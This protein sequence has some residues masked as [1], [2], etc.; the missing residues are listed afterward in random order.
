MFCFC[1]FNHARGVG[2]DKP[3]AEPPNESLRLSPQTPS[4]NVYVNGWGRGGNGGRTA[5]FGAPPR[6]RLSASDSDDLENEQE[7]KGKGKPAEAV[8]GELGG[9]SNIGF[10]DDALAAGGAG[11]GD[12]G[13]TWAK[14]PPSL[15]PPP[16]PATVLPAPLGRRRPLQI[17]ARQPAPAASSNGSG[18]VDASKVQ[19]PAVADA[20]EAAGGDEDEDE[21]EGEGKGEESAAGDGGRV[22][23]SS[24]SGARSAAAATAAADA[25]V[26]APPSASA[27]APETVDHFPCSLSEAPPPPSRSHKQS[28]PWSTSSPCVISCSPSSPSFGGD[29]VRLQDG[30]GSGSGSGSGFEHCARAVR[31]CELYQEC[32]HILMPPAASGNG[33][34]NSKGNG[35]DAGRNSGGGGDGGGFATLMHR[36]EKDGSMAG[37]EAAAAA[38]ARAGNGGG[39]GSGSGGW[40]GS[41]GGF[42][43][44]AKPRTYYVVSFGGSGSKMLG[45]WLSERGKGMVKEVRRRAASI[46]LGVCVS[47][48]AR[49]MCHAVNRFICWLVAHSGISVFCLFLFF[50][51]QYFLEYSSCTAVGWLFMTR[52]HILNPLS[53]Q[54]VSLSIYVRVL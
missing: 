15:P 12:E 33:N 6:G 54:S 39:G 41:N 8:G 9:N 10:T 47:Y 16:P 29:E 32:T 50:S 11:R 49:V 30:R 45:G 18:D 31:A 36:A 2:D 48:H 53:I 13:G 23:S 19:W 1:Q 22:K 26:P 25:A 28:G 3:D 21:G 7:E 14:K 38:A 37:V 24:F 17:M 5:D 52:Y 34:G 27:P 4:K 44:D 51:H 42:T 20:V 40:G 43:L 46:R 35:G